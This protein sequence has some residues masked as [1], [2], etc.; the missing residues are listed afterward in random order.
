M[1]PAD[2]LGA[3]MQRMYCLESTDENSQRQQTG[4]RN[5][6]EQKVRSPCS[7]I[8]AQV[9]GNDHHLA[10]PR[11]TLRRRAANSA[12]RS[13]ARWLVVSEAGSTGILFGLPVWAALLEIPCIS[14]Q[15]V[16][17]RAPGRV[18]TPLRPT[19]FLLKCRDIP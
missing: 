1:Y 3:D 7:P 6:T 8:T 2:S 12:V 18:K 14:M 11:A 5:L 10:V 15:S 19:G 13:D 16:P 9:T 4:Y 17:F